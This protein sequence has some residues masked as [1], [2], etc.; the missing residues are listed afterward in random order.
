M[1]GMPRNE[2]LYG[3]YDDVPMAT[4]ASTWSGVLGGF[5]SLGLVAGGRRKPDHLTPV[6]V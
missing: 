1:V 5:V 6:L 2:G 4:V 3:K